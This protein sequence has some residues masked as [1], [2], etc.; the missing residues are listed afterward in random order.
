MLPHE[1][2][3]HNPQTNGILYYPGSGTDSGPLKLFG[4]HAAIKTV[5][6]ADYGLL[7]NDLDKIFAALDGWT[8]GTFED[9]LPTYFH[10]SNWNEFWPIDLR[11]DP[12]IANAF[13]I[14][15][16]LNTP[17]GHSIE[18]IFLG[19]EAIETFSVIS[20]NRFKPD[21]IVIQD[22]TWGNNWSQFG[23]DGHLH[24]TAIEMNCLPQLLFAAEN[25]RVWSGYSQVSEYADN[26]GQMHIHHR[27]IFEVS[28]EAQ[29]ALRL[30]AGRRKIEE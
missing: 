6:Y 29:T 24:K 22:H 14:A 19:T 4:E 28:S 17:N 30:R 10:K 2:L 5:I 3:Q 11:T 8:V 18:F 23:I 15:V 9:I 20:Q 25:T 13:G 1:Y 27:A 26:P 21:D 7:R 16:S 12:R